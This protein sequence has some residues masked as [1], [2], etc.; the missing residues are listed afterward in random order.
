MNPNTLNRARMLEHSDQHLTE[1]PKHMLDLW[2]QLT[3]QGYL[4]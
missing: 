1:M 4:F 2:F 3:E